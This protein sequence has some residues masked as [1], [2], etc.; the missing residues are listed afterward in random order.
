MVLWKHTQVIK[1]IDTN[2]PDIYDCPEGPVT[3][4]VE[5]EG[6]SLPANNQVFLGED[7]PLS[8][9]CCSACTRAA[10]QLKNHAG[11]VIYDVK[12]Y[13]FNGSSFIYLQSETTVAC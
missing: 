13:P 7:D 6:V 1:V 4:C 10:I 5:D 9:S 11:H 12:I 8:T 2:G 3:L